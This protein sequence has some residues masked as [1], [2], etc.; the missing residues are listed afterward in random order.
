MNTVKTGLAAVAIL[1]YGVIAVLTENVVG[2][3]TII[4]SAVVIAPVELACTRSTR[5]TE[6]YTG[7]FLRKMVSKTR[8]GFDVLYNQ[9][10]H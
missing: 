7:A 6:N 3:S 8:G 2:A 5:R 9:I 1:P 4:I 10:Y